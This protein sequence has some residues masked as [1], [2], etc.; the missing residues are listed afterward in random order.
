MT[1]YPVG[2][3]RPAGPA[4]NP[5]GLDLDRFVVHEDTSDPS[6]SG[7]E[8][9]G[10]LSAGDSIHYWEHTKDNHTLNGQGA[11]WD[12]AQDIESQ[13]SGTVAAINGPNSGAGLVEFDLFDS[14]TGG[15]F[16]SS[17]RITMRGYNRMS[18]FHI[19]LPQIDLA[20][21]NTKETWVQFAYFFDDMTPPIKD[22]VGGI[23]QEIP[24]FDHGSHSG[25]NRYAWPIPSLTPPQDTARFV[26]NI[27]DTFVNDSTADTLDQYP[28]SFG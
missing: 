16:T 26:E 14:Q 18:D 9:T 12:S 15:E 19:E 20:S 25:E 21:R 28:T 23:F 17:I 11:A 5:G 10:S 4:S 1:E 7:A 13:L 6:I 3:E 27:V 24:Y 2:Y 22:C 8:N